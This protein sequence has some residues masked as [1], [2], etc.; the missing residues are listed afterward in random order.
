MSKAKMASSFLKIK[1][2]NIGSV[3]IKTAGTYAVS[4]FALIQLS[5]IVVDNISTEEVLGITSESF[6]QLLFIVIISGFPLSLILAFIFKRKSISNE[7]LKDYESLK[8]IITNKKP[9]VGLIPFENLNDDSD[10]AFLVDGIVEDLITELSMVKEISVAT[11]K[12]CFGFRNKDYTTEAFKEEW[13]FDYVVSG[14]IRSSNDKLRISVELSD[15]DNDEVIWSNKYDKFKT[16]IFSLQDEIVTQIIFSIIGEIEITS[17]KRAHRKPTE[18]MTSYEY[19]LQGRALN[20]KFEKE[21]NA[22]AIKMLDAA[23]EADELNPLPHS[24]KACT[25]GQSM[26]LGFKER[27]EVMPAMLESLSKANELNDN[28]WNTNRILAEANLTMNNFEQTKLYATKAYRANPNNPHVLSIYGESLLRNGD[29]GTAIKIFEKMHELEPIVAADLN[30]DRPIQAKLFAYYSDG[31][32]AKCKE[33]LSLLEDFSS[34]TWISLLD[35]YVKN[36]ESYKEEL[37]YS[38]GLNKFKDINWDD[39][40]K[41]YH[42]SDKN[43]IESL[44]KTTTLFA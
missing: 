7:T 19:T 32:L 42:L 24:W 40:I 29:I 30:S 6:M 23:I 37:W 22:E 12:T 35:L 21:A 9:K 10:G 39:E 31:N 20:Q 34:K 36:N 27:D 17:L 11:R 25:L 26:F 5:S 13:G 41:T 3:L 28:D 16:D 8:K 14:S 33:L 15:M 1:F 43:M 2:H 44:T 4:G 38:K 18:S